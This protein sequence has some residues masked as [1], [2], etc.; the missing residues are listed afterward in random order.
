M[1]LIL[2]VLFLGFL[3][4]V[5]MLILASSH[6][7]AMKSISDNIRLLASFKKATNT[8]ELNETLAITDEPPE[9]E[10]PKEP[11]E[12]SVLPTELPASALSEIRKQMSS[13]SDL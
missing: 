2:S 6:K 5:G 8:R 12:P 3:Q 9:P 1:T 7:N 11:E 10:E 4:V 13:D